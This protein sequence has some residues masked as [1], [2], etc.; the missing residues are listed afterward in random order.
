MIQFHMRN[1]ILVSIQ[2]TTAL[3]FSAFQINQDILQKNQH[4]QK[5]VHRSLSMQILLS[6]TGTLQRQSDLA[7]S[8]HFISK[9]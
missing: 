2:T 9:Q 1:R 7:K 8:E 3:A 4:G 6:L 5:N